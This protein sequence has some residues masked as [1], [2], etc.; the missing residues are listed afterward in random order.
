MNTKLSYASGENL[1][2]FD[3]ASNAKKSQ[4]DFVKHE[5]HNDLSDEQLKEA[6]GLIVE[7]AKKLAPPE[8]KV[9]IVGAPVVVKT[10]L[11]KPL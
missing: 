5:S 7:A 8:K 3:I 10:E 2:V 4:A 1:V 6:Y 11:P 9:E